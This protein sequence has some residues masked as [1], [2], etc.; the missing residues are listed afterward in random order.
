MSIPKLDDIEI[1]HLNIREIPVFAK[2]RNDISNEAEHVIASRGERKKELGLRIL[3]QILLSE[4]RTHTFLAWHKGKAVGYLSLIFAKFKKFRGNAYL[5]LAVSATYRSK[6]I[7]SRLMDTAEVFAKDHGKRRM[8][9][10]VFGKNTKA[11]ELYKRRGYVIE[12]IKKDAVEDDGGYD[13][14]I[15]MTKTL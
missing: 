6:G 13:D 12:G 4:R 3:A 14:V 5:T 15:I 11:I 1:R 2:L 7:G 8:E 9:L 10:E